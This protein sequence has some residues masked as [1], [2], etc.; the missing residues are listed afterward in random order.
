[1]AGFRIVVTPKW[2]CSKLVVWRELVR[3]VP[4]TDPLGL[5]VACPRRSS[6]QYIVCPARG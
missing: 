2:N 3:R 4:D 6:N 1:M 5:E